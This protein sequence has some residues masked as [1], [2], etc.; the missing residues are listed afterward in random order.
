MPMKEKMLSV[1]LILTSL[2]GYLQWG[3]N[4][5]LFLLQAEGEILIK[6]WTEPKSVLH[7]LILLPMLGQILLTISV[8]Q[9]T[10]SRIFI[11]LGIASLSILLGFMFFI[12]VM[13]FNI[14]I[15]ASSLPFLALSG[16]TLLYF[17]SL[18]P[19]PK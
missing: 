15:L 5:H 2:L 12:G 16:Y 3:N 13:S 1:L 17:R 9:R 6:L 14:K 7:P 4:Q 19:Q 8:F 10:P 18:A 11:Y